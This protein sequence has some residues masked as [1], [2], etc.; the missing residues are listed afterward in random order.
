MG[1]VTV[2]LLIVIGVVLAHAQLVSKTDAARADAKKVPGPPPSDRVVLILEAPFGT[3]FMAG[4]CC[5]FTIFVSHLTSLSLIGSA[6]HHVGARFGGVHRYSTPVYTS[7][8]MAGIFD[9]I[10]SELYC[11]AHEALWRGG[12]KM[13]LTLSAVAVPIAQLLPSPPP[14]PPPTVPQTPPPMPAPVPPPRFAAYSSLDSANR[15]ELLAGRALFSQDGLHGLL[16]SLHGELLLLD[17]LNGRIIWR[18]RV[19]RPGSHRHRL[20]CQE[21]GNLVLYDENGKPY[22]KT[23]TNG[24]G[25]GPYHFV[26]QDDR[27]LVLYDSINTAIWASGTNENHPNDYQH[28]K[29]V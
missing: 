28:G 20:I 22:W 15:R 17:I 10:S 13:E 24:K 11:E 7:T 9:R 3:G 26:V 6:T 8:R 23:D 18:S 29:E 27:N 19:N 5:G 1:R 12:C 16:L 2:A 25:T 4:I 14:P 21:D